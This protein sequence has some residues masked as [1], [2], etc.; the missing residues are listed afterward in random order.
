M[1]SGLNTPKIVITERTP[2]L[3]STWCLRDREEKQTWNEDFLHK[4]TVA[5]SSLRAFLGLTQ[6]ANKTPQRK[7]N[8]MKP[9][10][11]IGPIML[12]F[13][14]INIF[15]ASLFH[16]H[17]LYCLYEI[18]VSKWEI[19]PS[20]KLKVRTYVDSVGIPM[21]IKSGVCKVSHWTKAVSRGKYRDDVLLRNC[22]FTITKI[23]IWK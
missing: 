22:Q 14:L 9:C 11:P 23:Q 1:L 7:P 4:H 10:G 21:E 18:N 6:A 2:T 3:R 15:I 20:E 12:C 16:Y 19:K 5:P 8:L 17:C 13:P